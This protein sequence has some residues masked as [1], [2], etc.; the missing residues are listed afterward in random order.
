MTN[1]LAYLYKNGGI[2]TANWLQALN[3]AQRG[4]RSTSFTGARRL[5][6]EAAA[7]EAKLQAAG[8]TLHLLGELDLP[9]VLTR[10][11]HPSWRALCDQVDAALGPLHEAHRFDVIEFAECMAMGF[12]PIQAKRVGLRYQSAQMLVKLH[13][14]NQWIRTANQE[15]MAD[16]D[17]LAIDYCERYAFDHADIQCSP[18]HYMLDYAHSVGWCVR[19]DAVV[20]P[21]A[22]PEPHGREQSTDLGNAP[23]VVFFGRLETRKGIELFIQA[24]ARLGPDI[25]I[26]FLGKDT[27]LN[28]GMLASDRIAA[29][30]PGRRVRLLVDLDQEDAIRYLTT[31]HRLA[32][33]PSLVDNFPNTVNRMP[34][35]PRPVSGRA[36]RGYT[37]DRPRTVVKRAG[38]VRGDS[39][40][41]LPR[42]PWL[43]RCHAAGSAEG[44]R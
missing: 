12:R 5:M 38:S 19:D 22:W 35:Q 23:E 8:I 43:H 11:P 4:W 28:D 21:Y 24:A 44:A 13:S 15:W 18:C 20:V 2:G 29:A 39:R 6:S 34:R 36:Y 9:E 3:L 1:E 31:G 40:G 33:M 17:S 27:R 30:M 41:P 7:A 42:A 14:S 16:T 10:F 26:T 25:A 32:V 37:G